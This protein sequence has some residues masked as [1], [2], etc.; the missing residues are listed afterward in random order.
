MGGISFQIPGFE[1]KHHRG[2]GGSCCRPASVVGAAVGS[3]AVPVLLQGAAVKKAA[4]L[5]LLQ[6]RLASRLLFKR[7][8]SELLRLALA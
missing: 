1:N 3:A 6:D 5:V 7:L 2:D 8:A 4:V